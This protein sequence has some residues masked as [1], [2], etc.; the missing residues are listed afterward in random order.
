MQL[1]FKITPRVLQV[2][3][4]EVDLSWSS[5]LFNWKVYGFPSFRFR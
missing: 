1:Y 3:T 4:C 5:S 2:V